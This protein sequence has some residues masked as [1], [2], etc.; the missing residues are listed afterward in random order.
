MKI[1]LSPTKELTKWLSIIYTPPD[2]KDKYIRINPKTEIIKNAFDRNLPN[3]DLGSV[4]KIA[5]DVKT[6]NGNSIGMLLP[7]MM[8]L[9][10]IPRPK[11]RTMNK[12]CIFKRLIK[13]TF[14][15]PHV[16]S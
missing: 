10:T 8:L 11:I 5:K 3:T 4:I 15:P 14:L 16:L 13:I 1:S 9:A 7:R 2:G 12:N 6:N